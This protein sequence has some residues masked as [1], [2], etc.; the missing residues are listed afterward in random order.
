[1]S[2][3]WGSPVQHAALTLTRVEVPSLARWT[4]PT[5]ASFFTWCDAV[6]WLIPSSSASAPTV[7]APTGAPATACSIR[8]RIG[9]ARQ[10]NQDA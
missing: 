3:A 4:K 1:M 2:A 8:T 10:A 7:T 9:S 5:S 6:D